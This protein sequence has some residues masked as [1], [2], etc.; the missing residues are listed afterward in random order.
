MKTAPK[1]NTKTNTNDKKQAMTATVVVERSL[2]FTGS[3]GGGATEQ[4]TR[5]KAIA[6]KCPRDTL[7]LAA[8]AHTVQRKNPATNELLC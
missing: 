4:Q 5:I 3:T 7:V 8:I 6:V 1:N 2:D